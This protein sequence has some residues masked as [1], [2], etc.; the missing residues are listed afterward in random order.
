MLRKSQTTG[1]RTFQQHDRGTIDTVYFVAPPFS[2]IRD[3]VAAFAADLDTT[4]IYTLHFAPPNDA[5]NATYSEPQTG[6][7]FHY[8]YYT[9]VTVICISN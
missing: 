7:L 1:S 3:K 5:T 6:L 9:L 2:A 4:A 8:I